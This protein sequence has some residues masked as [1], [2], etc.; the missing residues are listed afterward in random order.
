MLEIFQKGGFVMWGLLALAIIAIAIILERFITLYMLASANP[1]KL[2]QKVIDIIEEQGLKEALDYLYDNPSP[3][4]KVLAAGLEKVQQGKVAF[5]DAMVRK[6]VSELAFLDRNMIYLSSITTIAPLLGFIGT[7]IG[8]MKAFNTI[9]ITGEV[10]PELV[11]GGIS[12]ALIATGA[13][14]IIAAPAAL[15]YA[16][17][18]NRINVYQR[19][20][21]EASNALVE[22]LLE[23]GIIVA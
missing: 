13:G 1:L 11:A 20:I 21:E 9:R 16:I 4:A 5:E 17:F 7:I 18:T 8:L 23:K 19:Q 22:Y 14:F 6:A 12:E 2:V 3:L 10:E 15:F